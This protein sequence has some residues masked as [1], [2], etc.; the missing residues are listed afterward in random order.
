MARYR[1]APARFWEWVPLSRICWTG[2]CQARGSCLPGPGCR[3]S[4]PGGL[5]PGTE[6]PPSR[7][8]PA[9]SVLLFDPAGFSPFQAK[10]LAAPLVPRSVGLFPYHKD[11]KKYPDN[12]G[13]RDKYFG[14]IFVYQMI[15]RMANRW[16]Y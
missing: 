13:K 2:A 14:Y 6:R 8:T 11:T 5:P 16:R 1:P 15:E 12:Q 7:R 9:G 4:L 3:P 10:A